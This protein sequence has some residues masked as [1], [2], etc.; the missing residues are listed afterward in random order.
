MKGFVY[1]YQRTIINRIK[2]ALKRPVTYL[3]GIFV[4]LYI[5]MIYKSFDMMIQEGDFNSPN[6]MVTILSMIIYWLIPGNLISYAKR[7]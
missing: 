3:M 2:K 4:L 6:N 7:K 5:V 1:L